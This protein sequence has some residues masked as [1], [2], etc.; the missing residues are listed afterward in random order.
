VLGVMIRLVAQRLGPLA[1][2]QGLSGRVPAASPSP[3]ASFPFASR[4]PRAA[5]LITVDIGCTG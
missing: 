2:R 1:R 3:G 4:D 5:L